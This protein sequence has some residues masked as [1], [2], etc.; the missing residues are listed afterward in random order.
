MLLAITLYDLTFYL[1]ALALLISSKASGVIRQA[2]VPRL[3]P[4]P[5]LL[6][7]ANSSIARL[8]TIAAGVGG[9][10][11]ALIL[12][13]TTP[14]WLLSIAAVVF[15]AAALAG[16]AVRMPENRH[17]VAGEVEYAQLHMPAVVYAAGGLLALRGAVGYFVFLLAFSL[18]RS[19]EPPWVY[20]LAVVLYGRRV[21]PRQRR[22][23]A[24]ATALP[25]GA[26]AGRL[27]ARAGDRD[28]RSDCS[29]SPARWC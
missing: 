5:E 21:V 20:G 24:A 8:G 17:E 23:A 12:A 25:R 9:G 22:C 26:V 1:M 3:V 14:R 11:G 29:A 7:S 16:T 2:L 28:R 6:V 13:T 4:D 15:V 18:R 19:S 27:A 10:I